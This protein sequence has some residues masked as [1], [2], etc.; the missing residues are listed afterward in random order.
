MFFPSRIDLALSIVCL[1]SR[2]QFLRITW[3]VTISPCVV[4]KSL[5]TICVTLVPISR[6]ISFLPMRS[7]AFGLNFPQPFFLL[8]ISLLEVMRRALWAIIRLEQ[9]HVRWAQ[10]LTNDLRSHLT[11]LTVHLFLA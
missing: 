7:T 4:H 11:H 10:E 2:A 5:P 3:V 9:E 1:L 8:G 6:P